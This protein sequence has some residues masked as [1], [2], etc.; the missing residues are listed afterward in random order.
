MSVTYAVDWAGK[1]G[2]IY[3][4]PREVLSAGNRSNNERQE[5][6]RGHSTEVFSGRTEQFVVAKY[7][8]ETGQSKSECVNEESSG[9]SA[10]VTQNR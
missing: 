1:R 7:E 4:L 10:R 6:S 9:V 2:R 3:V 5:V 8:L